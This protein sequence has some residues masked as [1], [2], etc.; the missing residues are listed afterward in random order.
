MPDASPVPAPNP[1]PPA[2]A[3]R[4]FERLFG[5]V[6]L[7]YLPVLLTYFCYGAS[8]ITAIALVYLQKD[9]LGL[10]P[11]EVAAIGFWAALPWSMKM[12]A[13]AASDRYPILGSRRRPYLLLGVLCALVG[14]GLIAGVVS[15]KGLFL[16]A[17]V[18]VAVGFMVQDVIADALSVEIA[19]TDEEIAQ[20]QTLG[21]MAFLAGT[22]SVGY[23]SGEL[24]ARLGPRAVF[25]VAMVLPVLV[26]LAALTLRGEVRAAPPAAEGPLGAGRAQLVIGVGLAYAVLGVLLEMLGVP[27]AQEII[28]VVS[29]VLIVLLLQRI[30]LSRAV[31]VAAFVIFLF[32]AAPTVGQGYSYWAIDGLG[33]DQRF[34]GVLAQVS[35]V[36]GLVGLIL[37][38]KP[39]ARHPVSFTLTWVILVATVLYLPSI[40]LFYG[41]HQWLGISA[42]ALAF[43]DTTIS[44]PLAQLT[45]VPMLVLIAKTAPAGAEATMFAIMA[46]L[47]N[48]ALSASELFTRYL[49][50]FFHVTQQDYSNLG[51]LMIAVAV[52]GLVPLLSIP[53]LRREEGQIGPGAVVRAAPAT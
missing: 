25:A 22:I 32:R 16:L 43:I 37:F 50:E 5:T 33:F 6:R 20:V 2:V 17:M 7:A 9:T 44:A 10:V 47:M 46:S 40:G 36:L 42:H 52:L 31:A 4:L 28:L 26:A 41:L 48:L 13:G 21:R 45:M 34:L 49:N 30:G 38:R 14:Y 8:G 53:L 15:T 29:A 24:T 18:L 27:Y 51:R 12:V 19:R 1:P 11:A 35:A 39:I 3:P 23:L